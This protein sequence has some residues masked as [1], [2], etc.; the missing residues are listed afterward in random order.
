[1]FF[2]QYKLALHPSPPKQKIYLLFSNNQEE[3]NMDIETHIN[4]NNNNKE[5]LTC[6][7][8]AHGITEDCPAIRFLGGILIQVLTTNLTSNKFLQ[9]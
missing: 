8:L 2:R 7:N 1:L 5:D 3:K 9:N 4:F 6:L